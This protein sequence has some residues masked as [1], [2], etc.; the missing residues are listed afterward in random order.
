MCKKLEQVHHEM[1]LDNRI[2][3][4]KL[5]DALQ[6]VQ[7]GL[8]QLRSA[9]DA[10]DARLR[11]DS[12][13]QDQLAEM[14]TGAAREQYLKLEGSAVE[15]VQAHFE[16]FQKT[17]EEKKH[18]SEAQIGQQYTQLQT[19]LAEIRQEQ[20]RLHEEAL[21]DVSRLRQTYLQSLEEI[22]SEIK[23]LKTQ[24]KDTF[25]QLFDVLQSVIDRYVEQVDDERQHKLQFQKTLLALVERCRRQNEGRE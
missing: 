16:E 2:E 10:R 14:R 17:L 21:A 15:L 3:F 23:S 5:A 7:Q 12:A 9:R 24:R 8:E 22:K 13:Q 20:Q 18:D 19:A 11:S 6:Q 4:L 1:E 25:G